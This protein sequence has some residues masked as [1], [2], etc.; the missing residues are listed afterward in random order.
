[1]TYGYFDPF[2]IGVQPNLISQTKPS[3]LKLHGFGFINPD[4]LSDIKVKF[5]SP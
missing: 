4:N 3:N 2:V 1:L 5:T